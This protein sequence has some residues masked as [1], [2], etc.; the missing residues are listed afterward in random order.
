MQMMEKNVYS[1]YDI[2]SFLNNLHVSGFYCSEI[3]CMRKVFLFDAFFYV[4]YTF[5]LHTQQKRQFIFR[6]IN[7][8]KSKLCIWIKYN[9]KDGRVESLKP[10]KLVS[11]EFLGKMP[12]LWRSEAF[13]MSYIHV[14]WMHSWIDRFPNQ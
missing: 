1:F 5:S 3:M 8:C 14:H 2:L 10:W 7:L 4:I 13:D 12:T 11:I 6:A 9:L